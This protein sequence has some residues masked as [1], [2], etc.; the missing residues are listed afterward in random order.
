MCSFQKARRNDAIQD[1]PIRKLDKFRS[2][3]KLMMNQK[4]YQ[5]DAFTSELYK[6]NP[7]GVCIL[8]EWISDD[9]MQNIALENNLA[10]TAFMVR[11]ESDGYDLR[12]FTPTIE[13]QLCGHATLASAHILFTEYEYAGETINFETK[14]G[15]LVVSKIPEDRYLMDFPCDEPKSV[16][17]FAY[18]ASIMNVQGLECF[19]GK[20]DFLLILKDEK[21]VLAAQ[22]DLKS[23]SK[24]KSR[25]VIL[26]AP[27]AKKDFVSRCF[28]PNAGVDEDPVTGS[29]HTLLT[30]YWAHA[31]KKNRL[32]AR[33]ISSRGGDVECI[34]KGDRVSLIGSA[35]TYLKGWI[36]V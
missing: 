21:A 28:F 32:M 4:I 11:N 13:V 27:G 36:S 26:S 22:P 35:V 29:A 8:N 14:S 33:Q 10:E 1:N 25:G 15:R 17:E 31:L 23:M 16:E 19:Q 12:W 5:V 2:Q 30:P 9:H 34:Y 18:I 20:D 6:G 24:I 7:A 3:I